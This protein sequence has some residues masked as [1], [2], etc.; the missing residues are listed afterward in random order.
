DTNVARVLARLSGRRLSGAEVQ[1]LADALV[2]PSSGWVWNQA[3]LDVGALSCTKRAPRCDRCPL[4]PRCA[5]GGDGPDPAVG[6]AR[7]SGGQSR[8]DGSDR[9]GRGRLVAALRAG[10]VPLDAL[11]STMGWP[12]DPARAHRVAQTVVRDRLAVVVDNRLELP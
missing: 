1:R 5:W 11:A 10:P 3:M 4:R 9:Q 12:D 8:F 7:V 2:P 6:S